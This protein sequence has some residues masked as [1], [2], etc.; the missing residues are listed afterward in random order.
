MGD[1]ETRRLRLGSDLVTVDLW[2]RSGPPIL[3]LHG[4]PGWRGT[5]RA[6]ASRLA[7]GHRIVA[8]DL[9]G[10]G[11][12]SAPA[13][14]FH[15]AEEA[16]MARSLLEALHLERV[17]LVGFDFGGPIA[18]ALAARDPRVVASLTLVATNAFPDTPVPLPL[19]VARVPILGE[20]VFRVAFGRAGLLALWRAAAGD[21]AAFPRARYAESLRSPRGVASTRRV[22]LD[23]L[24]HLRA[25]YAGAEAALSRLAVPLRVLWGDRDPFFPVAVGERTARTGR[26][27]LRV[28]PGC[29]HFVPEERP[30]E[31]ADEV[32]ALV[33]AAGGEVA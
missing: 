17:H 7:P 5:W 14:R 28:L 21:R 3:C 6:V 10:F 22:L 1:P 29:G 9:L 8:P 33:G 32:A 18:L 19:R 30:R 11:E 24:R 25:R 31:V 26:G 12:S 23:S 16:A 13:G 15:A 4:I 27:T 20:A 2:G